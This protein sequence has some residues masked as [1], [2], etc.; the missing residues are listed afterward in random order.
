MIL[1][2]LMI[3]I[4]VHLNVDLFIY[5]PK[6]G[7]D[8]TIL[9]HCIESNIPTVF[10]DD[11]SDVGIKNK[12]DYIVDYNLEF[13]QIL[14]T[15]DFKYIPYL[16]H[17]IFFYQLDDLK[18]LAKIQNHFYSINYSYKH[19]MLITAEKDLFL[20]NSVLKSDLEALNFEDNYYYCFVDVDSSSGFIEI[21]FDDAT[22]DGYNYE[23]TI[24]NNSD[25]K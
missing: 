18:D 23:N 6:T 9:N 16:K 24:L 20:S 3:L 17:I 13:R 19:L 1:K 15:I 11:G 22:F 10:L 4:T 14:D 7:L 2:R 12:F 8:E 25:F 5:N 21:D